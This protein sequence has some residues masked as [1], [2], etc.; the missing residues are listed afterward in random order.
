M[1]MLNR[2]PEIRSLLLTFTVF[3]LLNCTLMGIG[4]LAWFNWHH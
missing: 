4:F 3:A 1:E 2:D